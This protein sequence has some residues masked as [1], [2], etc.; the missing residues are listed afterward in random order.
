M[1][2]H[3]RIYR[4]D[5][6]WQCRVHAPRQGGP[7]TQCGVWLKLML[8]L[9]LILRLLSLGVALGKRDVTTGTRR[10]RGFLADASEPA[11][12]LSLV[13]LL[14]AARSVFCDQ[15]NNNKTTRGG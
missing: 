9:I 8:M 7:R 4:Q 6:I 3:E 13:F 15:A 5:G 10:A 14:V 12:V 11:D 2:G 1:A